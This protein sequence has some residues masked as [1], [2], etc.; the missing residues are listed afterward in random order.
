MAD[1]TQKNPETTTPETATPG[2]PSGTLDLRPQAGSIKAELYRLGLRY[3]GPAQAG[4]ELWR[5]YTAGLTATIN[6]DGASLT[7]TVT[8][9]TLDVTAAQLKTVQKI[10]TVTTN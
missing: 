1:E 6:G 3:D 10:V 4:G 9:T 7:D 8:N 5:D 2:T